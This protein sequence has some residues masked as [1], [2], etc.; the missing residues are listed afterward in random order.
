MRIYGS[1]YAFKD[2]ILHKYSNPLRNNLQGNILKTK[3]FKQ[4]CCRNQWYRGFF[5]VH[6]AMDTNL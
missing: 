4:Y 3:E 5:F 2:N 6:D 1:S